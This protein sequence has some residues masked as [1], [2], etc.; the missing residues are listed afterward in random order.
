MI[1]NGGPQYDNHGAG[2]PPGA[3]C[4]GYKYFVN[5]VEPADKRF[6]IRCC[7]SKARDPTN[8]SF[9][10][11]AYIS[12]YIRLTAIRDDRNM[13]VFVSF[14]AITRILRPKETTCL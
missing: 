13:A 8:S 14:Q 12:S 6:C 10:F 9:F 1:T 2:K 4:A 3:Q 7:R 11:F 5:L